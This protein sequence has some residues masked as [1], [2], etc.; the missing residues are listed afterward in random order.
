MSDPTKLKIANYGGLA[1]A[2]YGG[3][4]LAPSLAGIIPVAPRQLP[5]VGA[6][7]GAGAFYM[8]AFNTKGYL[9]IFGLE[10]APKK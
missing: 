10:P 3:Y 6:A 2:G 9:D 7:I 8:L 5:M 1:A 4:M